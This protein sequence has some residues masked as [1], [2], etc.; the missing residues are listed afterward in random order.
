MGVCPTA[1][2]CTHLASTCNRQELVQG[3]WEDLWCICLCGFFSV[4]KGLQGLGGWASTDRPSPSGHTLSRKCSACQP[5]ARP[6]A[7]LLGPH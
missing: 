3:S 4:S 6:A 2:A 7:M 5:Q 1:V